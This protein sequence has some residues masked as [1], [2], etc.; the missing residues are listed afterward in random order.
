MN[1][2]VFRVLMIIT[3]LLFCS[4][5]MSS[6]EPQAPSYAKW[7]QLAMKTAKAKYPNADIVDYLHIGRVDKDQLSTEKFK[8]WLKEGGKEFGLFIDIE[9]NPTNDR[10]K[11]I[12][13]KKSAT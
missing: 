10:V 9:F 7:G 8:L 3:I 13:F 11:Q 1:Q 2:K 4:T 12:L 5:K 6:A